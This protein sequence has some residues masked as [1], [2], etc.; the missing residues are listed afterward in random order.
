[1]FLDICI[2]Q[3]WYLKPFR[4]LIICASLSACVGGPQE[5]PVSHRKPPP[6]TKLNYHIVSA[7]ETLYSIAWRYSLD[8]KQLARRN[9]IS[10]SYTIYPG[11][12]L[13]LNL[14]KKKIY[15]PVKPVKPV[16][17]PKSPKRSK[18]Q[19]TSKV[20]KVTPK[21][22]TNSMAWRWP[23]KGKLLRKFSAGSGLNKGIDI[24]GKLGEPV[25]SAAPGH[26]VYA[27]RGLRGYGNLL[28]IKHNEKFLSAYAHSRKL[29]VKE[30]QRVKAGQKIAEIGSSG[31]D[32]NK[33]HFEIRREG[34]PV[35]PLKYL[36]KR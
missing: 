24:V 28:I 29:L 8:Y 12:K 36:P 32:R 22:K 3:Q 23:V 18:S 7:G 2:N 17:K 16:S 34:K 13:M 6:S 27:G 31:T 20:A 35:D 19:T 30:G 1:M 21:S 26:V 5:A 10:R 4:I 33:L 15:P 11:Q 9:G 25:T 14:T